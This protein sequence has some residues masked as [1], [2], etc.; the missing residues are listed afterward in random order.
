MFIFIFNVIC[1]RVQRSIKIKVCSKRT[2]SLWNNKCTKNERPMEFHSRM[3]DELNAIVPNKWSSF[4][5]LT[6]RLSVWIFFSSAFYSSTT[7]I[8]SHAN[9][10]FMK[11]L[12]ATKYVTIWSLSLFQY[13][14]FHNVVLNFTKNFFVT[15][16]G[17]FF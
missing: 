14:I 9:S 15:W 7:L 16:G 8:F 1:V 3:S 10:H 6:S 4:S 2:I 17:S 5:R 13:W 12:I 11:F